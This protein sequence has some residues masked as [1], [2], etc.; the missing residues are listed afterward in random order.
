MADKIKLSIAMFLVIAGIA[1]YYML[2]EQSTALR[3]LPVLAGVALGA[4]LAVLTTELGKRFHAFSKDSW[5]EARKVVW[6]TRKESVQ[7][8]GVVFVFVVVMAIF[9]WVVDASLLWAVEKV[10]GSGG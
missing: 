3:I 1:G 9:L 4:L 10:M 6:P 8:T 5:E 2:A 7:M